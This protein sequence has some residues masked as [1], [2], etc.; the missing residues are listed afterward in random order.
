MRDVRNGSDVV[1]AYRVVF[2]CFNKTTCSV[3]LVSVCILSTSTWLC[4]DTTYL[5]V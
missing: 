3:A 2:D 5:M 1:V 4:L